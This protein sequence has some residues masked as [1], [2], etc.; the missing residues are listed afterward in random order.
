MPQHF[1][2]MDSVPDFRMSTRSIKLNPFTS[3]LYWRMNWHAEHH[4]FAAVPGY[5]LEKLAR[6]IAPDMPRLRTLWQAWA[7]MI[8]SG[9]RQRQGLPYPYQ[10][11]LPATAHPAVLS[12]AEVV[13]PE[14]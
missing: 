9:K 11:P 3:F 10:T 6:E 12:T 13:L 2:L 1:G 5:H 14:G 7:E 4:M 8:Q